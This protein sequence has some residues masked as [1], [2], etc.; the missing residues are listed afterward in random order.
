MPD[1]IA[2]LFDEFLELA[3]RGQA[4]DVEV[5]LAARADLSEHERERVR[6]LAQCLAGR[7]EAG[8]DP[9]VASPLEIGEGKTQPE[10][11]GPFRLLRVLGH[12]G[13]ATVY[14][15]I[16]TRLKRHVAVKVLFGVG[17]SHS[18]PAGRLKREAAL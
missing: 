3:L 11:L 6:G 10:S 7:Q 17:D 13:Q 16:D 8:A 4:G 5:F 2:L 15:A 14:L 9:P 12:G 1:R 18:G